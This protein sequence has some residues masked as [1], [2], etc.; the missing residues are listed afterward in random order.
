[1]INKRQKYFT[2]NLIVKSAIVFQ[3]SQYIDKEIERETAH[4]LICGKANMA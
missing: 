2:I 3:D 1:V 4:S